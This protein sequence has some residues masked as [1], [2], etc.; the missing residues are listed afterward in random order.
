MTRPSRHDPYYRLDRLVT[1]VTTTS[2]ATTPPPPPRQRQLSPQHNAIPTCHRLDCVTTS[3]TSTGT[4]RCHVHW[5]CLDSATTATSAPLRTPP[6]R[7]CPDMV[8]TATPICYDP[9]NTAR[10]DHARRRHLNSAVTAT[11]PPSPTLR[12]PCHHILARQ[13]QAPHMVPLPPQD[14][15]HSH[16]VAAAPGSHSDAVASRKPKSPQLSSGTWGQLSGGS[17]N[18]KGLAAA[19]SSVPVPSSLFN[20]PQASTSSAHTSSRPPMQ[21]SDSVATQPLDSHHGFILASTIQ[22]SS[23]VT[24]TPE[25]HH[26]DNHTA[27]PT[28]YGPADKPCVT[29]QTGSGLPQVEEPN[30][31]P[32]SGSLADSIPLMEYRI[33]VTHSIPVGHD[34]ESPQEGVPQPTH[35]APFTQGIE[36]SCS[37]VTARSRDIILEVIPPLTTSFPYPQENQD[38][39]FGTWT[40][41]THPEGALYFYDEERRLFTDTDMSDEILRGEAEKF[42]DYLQT[43]PEAKELASHQQND[44]SLTCLIHRL[45]SDILSLSHQRG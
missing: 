20:P 17:L 5:R 15:C 30:I 35:Q 41:A 4:Q 37:Y 3:A 26:R 38:G 24:L 42:Y 6:H 9:T 29:E 39:R 14:Y 8:A 43:S 1:T 10:L 18:L 21:G 12:P 13:A 36:Q 16:P 25:L 32:G 44:K 11:Q 34:A 23:T 22:N 19:A 33:N 31:Q 45:N 28:V 7:R 2:T 40:P 27:G